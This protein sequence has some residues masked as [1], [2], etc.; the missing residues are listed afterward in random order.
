MKR[1]IDKKKIGKVLDC[2][3]ACGI[4]RLVDEMMGSE[5]TFF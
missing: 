3:A 1:I 2:K 4:C 5:R